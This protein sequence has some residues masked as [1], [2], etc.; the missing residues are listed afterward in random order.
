MNTNPKLHSS[1]HAPHWLFQSNRHAG[2][3]LGKR[4]GGGATAAE[5]IA[6]AFAVAQTRG[7]PLDVAHID[8]AMVSVENQKA[9]NA[10]GRSPSA[11]EAAR[12]AFVDRV[13]QQAN[14]NAVADT[15]FQLGKKLDQVS[16]ANDDNG[17]FITKRQ[18][19]TEDR[20]MVVHL[21]K[22]HGFS[23]EQAKAQAHTMWEDICWAARFDRSEYSDGMFLKKGQDGGK[24]AT[25]VLT[26]L[27][28]LENYAAHLQT[29]QKAFDRVASQRVVP[30][31]RRESTWDDLVKQANNQGLL[32]KPQLDT[33]LKTVPARTQSDIFTPARVFNQN[34]EYAT[35]V[36]IDHVLSLDRD[37][38]Q[39]A[40]Q[41]ARPQYQDS[42]QFIASDACKALFR[43][44][45]NFETDTP[46]QT[47]RFLFK[48][49]LLDFVREVDVRFN[50]GENTSH[51]VPRGSVQELQQARVDVRAQMR[52]IQERGDQGI[53]MKDYPEVRTQAAN[54]LEALLNRLNAAIRVRE[55][56]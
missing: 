55:A 32:L 10:N 34:K 44:T 30:Q 36:I 6:K 23:D 15:N 35:K 9:L 49:R 25:Q 45:K 40:S 26:R 13:R 4:A 8:R 17:M 31:A 21:L 24:D 27:Q 18:M 56:L 42:A 37:W 20:S 43:G 22:H 33:L 51:V 47:E 41:L 48:S 38:S 7:W 28:S 53:L 5:P 12:T 29:D 19:S 14:A 50:L 2:A 16:W 39:P 3:V 1:N 52:L 54:H 46:A 11:P